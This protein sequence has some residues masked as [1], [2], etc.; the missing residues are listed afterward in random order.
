MGGSSADISTT[1]STTCQQTAAQV[2]QETSPEEV[3]E[4]EEKW[5]ETSASEEEVWK[6]T[7]AARILVRGAGVPFKTI[8]QPIP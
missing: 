5:Q 8:V 2:W 4:P 6:Q 7:A 1:F 3:E